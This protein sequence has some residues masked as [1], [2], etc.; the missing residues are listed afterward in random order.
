MM[1]NVIAL[2]IAV[3]IQ[4]ESGGDV[5]AVGDSGRAVGAL[6]MWEVSVDEANRLEALQARRDGTVARSWTYQDRWSLEKSIEM[7]AVILRFHYGRG[8]QDVVSLAARWRNPY[9]E[10]PAWYKDRVRKELN[11]QQQQEGN[12]L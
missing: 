7:A 11:R 5:R 3:L 9:S 12:G 10:C 4:V 2:T 1:T 6:Q 8:N